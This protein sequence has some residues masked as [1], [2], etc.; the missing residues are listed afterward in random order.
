MKHCLSYFFFIWYYIMLVFFL[1]C[2]F[3]FKARLVVLVVYSRSVWPIQDYCSLNRMLI[4]VLECLVKTARGSLFR[5]RA[6]KEEKASSFAFQLISAVAVT[7]LFL[8]LSACL[9]VHLSVCL[10]VRLYFCLPACFS[11][12]Q[13]VP[14]SFCPL[15]S[16]NSHLG[17]W[18]CF[19]LC[20][21][22]FVS[23]DVL[24]FILV[25]V[26]ITMSRCRCAVCV[27]VCF[28]PY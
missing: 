2:A 28:C 3:H 5:S 25:Y 9:S 20:L 12:F 13:S 1:T 10:S 27:C 16:P 6:K 18:V 21:S 23:A 17:L 14:L 15:G 24:A 19:D 22:V 26:L 8:L 11:A 4:L 7:K